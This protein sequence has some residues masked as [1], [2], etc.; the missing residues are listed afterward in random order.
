MSSYNMTFQQYI[1]KSGR[2]TFSVWFLKVRVKDSCQ[3]IL[4]LLKYVI[5][6]LSFN[7]ICDVAL[8]IA[9]ESLLPL[10]PLE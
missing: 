2:R 1:V 8:A 7:R 3:E 6:S 10:F 5:D 4:F 9:T